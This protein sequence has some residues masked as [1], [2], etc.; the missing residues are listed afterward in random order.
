MPEPTIPAT[1]LDLLAAPPAA[2]L[3]TIGPTGHPQL[4]AVWAISDGDTVVISVT[5]DRQKA[6]NLRNRPQATLFVVDP[7]NPQRTLE[8]RADVTV[9]SDPELT[10]LTKVLSAYGLDL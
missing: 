3:A 2:T 1:H 6:K 8:V 10:G 5:E 7:A 4:T 9:E